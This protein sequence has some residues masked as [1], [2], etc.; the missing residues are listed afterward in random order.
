MIE[1]FSK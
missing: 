1:H